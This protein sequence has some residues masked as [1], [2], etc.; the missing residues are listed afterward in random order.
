MTFSNCSGGRDLGGLGAQGGQDLVGADV[1]GGGLVRI[2]PDA[3]GIVALAEQL[4]IGHAGQTR[5]LVAD[6]E[7]VV[8]DIFRAARAIRREDM[9]AQQ[10]GRHRL[11]DLH[12]LGLHLLREAR[13][14]VRDAVL[15]QHQVG[16]G[17]RPDLEDHGHRELAVPGRL[18][19]DVIHVLDA[20]DR[21][22]ERGGDG[23][24]HGFGRGARIAGH[25]LDR[26]RDDVGILGDRQQDH[27]RQTEHHDED[28]DHGREAR[29]LDEEVSESHDGCLNPG[30][31]ECR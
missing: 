21:L 29:V 14:G 17:V 8:R 26:G 20:V 11:L 16:I 2:D 19:G 23:A 5:E 3:H 18:A 22:F 13:Q 31:R 4:E 12:A 30:S 9:H 25:D 1:V 27:R 24:G 6:L 7:H 15:G 10:Q 28:I